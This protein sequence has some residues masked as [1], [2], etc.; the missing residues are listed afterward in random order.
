[1][2]EERNAPVAASRAAQP[3]KPPA[4]H[5]DENKTITQPLDGKEVSA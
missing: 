3:S 1:M 2:L 5:E 4:T